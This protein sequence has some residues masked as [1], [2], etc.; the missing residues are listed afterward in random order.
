MAAQT[1]GGNFINRR[2]SGLCA[3]SLTCLYFLCQKIVGLV[4]GAGMSIFLAWLILRPHKPRFYVDTVSLSQ[5][6]VTDRIVNS[7]M[8]FNVTVRN[9]N[10]KLGIYYHKMEWNVFYEDDRIASGYL[11]PFHQR[12]KTT[13]VLQP[14]LIG[15]NYEINSD[16]IARALAALDSPLELRLKLHANVRFKLGFCKS[17]NYKMRVECHHIYIAQKY[18]EQR[19]KSEIRVTENDGDNSIN[20]RIRCKVRL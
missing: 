14:V 7:R 18:S 19:F 9:P 12:H 17:W 6:N 1:R 16:D 3:S 10:G 2:E 15:D 20:Q 5:L 13:T 8:D 4:I 11:P